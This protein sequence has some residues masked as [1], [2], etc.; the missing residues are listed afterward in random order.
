[1]STD[2]PDPSPTEAA[3]I[4]EL[5]VAQG[6]LPA[7]SAAP[8]VEASPTESETE[9]FDDHS[10]A[11]AAA[12]LASEG[13]A[14]PPP[15]DASGEAAEGTAEP[16]STTVDNPEDDSGP[17]LKRGLAAIAKQANDLQVQKQNMEVEVQRRVQQAVPQ[18]VE[19]EVQ[20]RLQEIDRQIM[21]DPH[22][23]F[24]KRGANPAEVAAQLFYGDNAQDAPPEIRG[25]YEQLSMQRELQML[26]MQQQQ[27]QQQQ[28]QAQLQQQARNYMQQVAQRIPEDLPYLHAIAQE[29][30]GRIAQEM[31]D[32]AVQ[33]SAQGELRGLS[34]EVAAAVVAQRLDQKYA[35]NAKRYAPLA[36]KVKPV[37]K[38]PVA[39]GV[40]KT[41][42]PEIADKTKPAPKTL[43]NKT[44]AL[45]RP[46]SE[47][48]SHEDNIARVI[49]NL[50]R[51][52]LK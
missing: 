32:E 7:D 27:F 40:N 13:E 31:Y 41:A 47:A 48:L 46:S 39:N 23:Y 29:D 5:L 45:N 16:A 28:Q 11:A 50:R 17:N 10:E 18:I 43:N 33:L 38:A 8:P 1:M 12:E 21:L 35:Q 25:R 52:D 6:T 24:K 22:G 42:P 19:Q 26:R 36:S 37:T 49:D 15:A 44:G 4:R 20:R 9:V 51:G 2:L 34:D 14:V 3:A 30:R